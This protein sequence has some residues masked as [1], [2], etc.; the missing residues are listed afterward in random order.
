[1]REETA[2]D[3]PRASVSEPGAPVQISVVIVTWNAG[4]PLLD[5][6][7]SLQANPP[8]VGWEAI[9]VDNHSGDGSVESVRLQF[10]WAR[11]VANA[12][13][14]GLAAGNNQGIAASHAPFVLISNPDIIYGAGAIDALLDLLRRRDRAA[15]A[16]ANLRHPDGARQTSAGDLPTLAEA[17]TGQRVSRLR[18]GTGRRVWWH[19]W[20]AD[21]ERMVGHG[22]E[23]CYAVRRAALEQIGLQDERFV[24]D[25]EGLDWSARAWEAGW[26]VWFCPAANVIHLGGT[27]VRQATTRWIASTH[28]GMYRYFAAR[29]PA[30]LRPLLA[31]TIAVRAALKLLVS[32]TGV[33]LYDRAHRSDPR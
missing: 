33:R 16:I 8:S 28:L 10:P 32:I 18:S 11:V 3:F 12:R 29:V 24:L 9:V 2:E 14:R 7:R 20:A 21:E 30:I 6:L 31:L 19:D 23:A 5:C 25:W 1:M 17:L 27:S 15:F 22:A 13:N 4:E 26:E